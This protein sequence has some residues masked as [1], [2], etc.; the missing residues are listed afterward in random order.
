MRIFSG[1]RPTGDIHIGNYLGAIK[2]WISLQEE[3]DCLFCVVDLHAITTP[4]QPSELK[5]KIR[6]TAIS[7]LAAGLDPKKCILFTQS[8][9]K[10][11]L[12][13]FW[14]LNT[15]VPV[16]ELQRMTQFKDKSQQHEEYVNAGLLNYPV[17]MAADILLYNT[18]IVPIGLDQKQHVELTRIAAR[19]FN[20]QFGKTFKEPKEMIP[21]SGA[22]IMSLID[23]NKK[24]SK[25]GNP[26]GAI[27]LFESEESIKKKIMSATT[28]S[29]KDIKFDVANKPGISNLL[30]I[31]SLLEGTSIPELEKKF[32]DSSYADFKKETA[33]VVVKAL[34]PFREKFETLSKKP[35]HVDSILKKG[36][37][38]A[39]TIAQKTMK[40][41]NMKAGF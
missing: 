15:I 10:E 40:E 3:N 28:D 20:N 29:G 30:T 8:N 9:V 39:E 21:K 41:V 27:G 5:D 25:S 16:A 7:Y 24:M 34:L 33:E 32:K 17:L 35:K 13:L 26:K 1:I 11:H 36:A 18:D 38:K 37:K 22:K 19:K 2:Q 23:P 4:Y 31:Y 14:F 6:E 12:E